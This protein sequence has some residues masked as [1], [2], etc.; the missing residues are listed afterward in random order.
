MTKNQIEFQKLVETKRAN[1]ANEELTHERDAATKRLGLETL[2]ETA[3]HNQQV[4]LQAR[5]NLAE[6]QRN[7]IAQ[8]EEAQ[9]THLANEGI[10]QLN[11]DIE[12]RKAIEQQRHNQ[13]AEELTALTADVS[14]FAAEVGASSRTAAAGISAAASQ[15]MADASLIAKQ[16]DVDLGNRRIGADIGINTARISESRRESIARQSEINRANLMSEQQKGLSLAE[17]ARNNLV[18]QMLTREKNVADVNLRGQQLD[19][20]REQLGINRDT[21]QAQ[22]SLVPSQKFSNYTRGI[23]SLGSTAT[24]LINAFK[25]K[26]K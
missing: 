12:M 13:V 26:G 25:K 21:A 6:Q 20:N 17:Q 7:N 8:L 19:I 22:I 2:Q 1:R 18:N 9:R 23:Q 16:M 3:R 5:D 10:G 15:Y 14:R 4:E 24:S 11:A